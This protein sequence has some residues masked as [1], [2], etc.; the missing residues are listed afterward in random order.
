MVD[1]NSAPLEPNFS[2]F[3]ELFPKKETLGL[4]VLRPHGRVTLALELFAALLLLLTKEEGNE[5]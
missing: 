2:T 3:F 4:E 1:K 5:P